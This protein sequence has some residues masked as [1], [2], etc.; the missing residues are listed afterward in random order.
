MR[1]FIDDIEDRAEA[2][3][4]FRRVLYTGQHM[5]LVLMSLEP[6]SDTLHGAQLMLANR[7]MTIIADA[8]KTFPAT[9][10]CSTAPRACSTT[11][12]SS[13][14]PMISSPP[15]WCSTVARWS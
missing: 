12:C 13:W 2:N 11:S 3:R 14:V 4:D 5:Q 6:D 9:C 15:T 10:P 8:C 7:G 1:G